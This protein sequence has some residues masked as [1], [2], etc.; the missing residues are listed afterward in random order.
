[1]RRLKPFLA[2]S[3]GGRAAGGPRGP[4]E[5][6]LR[7]HSE[8]KAVD[9]TSRTV[10]GRRDDLIEGAGARGTEAW[11]LPGLDRGGPGAEDGDR[12]VRQLPRL[13]AHAR[14]GD[15]RIWVRTKGVGDG[16]LREFFILPSP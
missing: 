11:S 5:L 1:M 15:G 3:R 9:G 12:G 6:G 14:A 7:A 16:T 4:Q 13:D 2:R 8:G 10:H